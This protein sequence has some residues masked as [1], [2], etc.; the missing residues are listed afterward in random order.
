[1]GWR[2][3]AAR[4]PRAGFAKKRPAAISV[5]RY[6]ATGPRYDDAA[7][8]AWDAERWAAGSGRPAA[9]YPGMA[10]APFETPELRARAKAA[11]E[12]L[13]ACPCQ[14]H[15][16]Q[17]LRITHECAFGR[18]PG[19]GRPEWDYGAAIPLAAPSKPAPDWWT[20]AA[21]TVDA[22]ALERFA[23]EAYAA[24]AASEWTPE[25]GGEVARPDEATPKDKEWWE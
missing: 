10:A 2:M 5:P 12:A 6:E 23:A 14:A 8:P 11:G 22:S 4:K 21:A 17:L 15:A 24:L 9:E 19:P 25:D 7:R 20:A 1:M 13:T 18:D 16:D 3:S